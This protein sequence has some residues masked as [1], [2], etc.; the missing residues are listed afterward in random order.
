MKH[1]RQYIRK[2]LIEANYF[3]PPQAFKDETGIDIVHRYKLPSGFSSGKALQDWADAN[4]PKDQTPENISDFYAPIVDE[5][6]KLNPELT[7]LRDAGKVEEWMLMPD[8][9]ISDVIPWHLKDIVIGVASEFP[10]ADLLY[11]FDGSPDTSWNIGTQIEKKVGVRPQW[12]VSPETAAKQFGLQERKIRGY[13]RQ[14]L[15]TEGAKSWHAFPDDVVIV[16]EDLESEA[17][18]YYAIVDSVTGLPNANSS[19]YRALST[20]KDK[21]E[22]EIWGRI[23]IT[24]LGARAKDYG[25]CGGAMKVDVSRTAEGWGPLLYD[26]AIEYATMN[27]NGL[28]P[29]RHSVS[30]AANHVWKYYMRNRKD[31]TAYQL[32]DPYN[33]L[34][35]EDEDN[36][37]QEVAMEDE[38]AYDWQ[39]SPLSKRYT[40]EPTTMNTLKAA[41]K[42]VML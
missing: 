38:D 15:L 17:W 29:D 27:A 9:K 7:P 41:G 26:V 32:D 28:I 2:L 30:M 22:E 5:L 10:L 4:E 21:R 1:L 11:Y 19:R 12:M 34:T 8:E 37:D 42:L 25:Q 35:P 20:T 33:R 6:I 23:V 31:V 39:E 16:I 24:Q 3:S 36:C 14:I 13:I 18:I 40:K